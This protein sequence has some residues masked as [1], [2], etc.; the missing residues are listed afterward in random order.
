MEKSLLRKRFL[1]IR[2]S[3][4]PQEKSFLSSKIKENLFGL[5]E[6]KLAGSI[7]FYASTRSEVETLPMLKE[8]LAEKRCFLPK[9]SGDELK[10]FQ[11]KSLS[12]LSPG[13]YGI[14]EPNT[15]AEAELKEI[16]LII[17]PGVV[18]SRDG[19]RIGYGRGFYD[20]LLKK[21]QAIKIG[22]CFSCQLAE[23]IPK[24]QQDQRVDK[25]ITEDEVICCIH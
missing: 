8:A 22:L 20:R 25:I 11:V 13:Y 9:V 18:F 12:D 16:E 19:R 15:A 17:V 2:D 14:L 6:F 4:S 3:L 10:L 24:N 1:E 5:E 21:S 7:L 23:E